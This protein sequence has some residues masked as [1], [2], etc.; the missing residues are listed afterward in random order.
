MRVAIYARV[1]TATQVVDPQLQELRRYCAAR[2]W[3]ATEYID[4]GVSGSKSSRPGLNRMM[5]DARR[6]KFKAVVVYRFDRFGRSLKHLITALEEF[7][8]IDVNFISLHEAIDTGTTTGKLLFQV[9][10]AIAE[11][12]R[13][14]IAERI[15]SGME[16]AKEKLKSGPYRRRRN[17]KEV[18]VRSL[19]RPQKVVDIAEAKAMLEAG[20]SKA[21]VARHFSVSRS[22]LRGHLARSNG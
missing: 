3:D 2:E 1:S 21:N 14:L 15:R 10:A 17:G 16:A 11:F 5:A 13:D 19:G 4:E 22:T 8:E 7:R 18:V 12:E 6:R 20:T 9:I